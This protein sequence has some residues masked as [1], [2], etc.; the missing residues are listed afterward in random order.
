MEGRKDAYWSF[1]AYRGVGGGGL[2]GGGS[3]LLCGFSVKGGRGDSPRS[4]NSL[5]KG[6]V[7]DPP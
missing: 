2:L 1:V 4:I 7:T 3:G 5:K 6:L